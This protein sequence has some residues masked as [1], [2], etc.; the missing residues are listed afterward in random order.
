[1]NEDRE[2]EATEV[3]GSLIECYKTKESC[4]K[5]CAYLVEGLAL[6]GTKDYQ[7]LT[8]SFRY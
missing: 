4:L 1:M 2:E 5:G 8:A 6:R 7:I 3:G